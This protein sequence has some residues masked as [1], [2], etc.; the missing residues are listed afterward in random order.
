MTDF[1]GFN[2]D[3][4]LGANFN[5]NR[6]GKNQQSGNKPE[7]TEPQSTVDPYADLKMDPNRMLDLLAA[8]GKSNQA[9]FASTSS[10]ANIEKTMEAF[11]STM[12]PERHSL[13]SQMLKQ[14][15]QAEFG[16]APSNALLQDMVDDYLIG[17]VSTQGA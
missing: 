5:A 9:H 2:P 16:K 13:T 14:T 8:Q 4:N 15:Y 17:H 12:S 7:T 11:T 10:A 6:H 1:K 3:K